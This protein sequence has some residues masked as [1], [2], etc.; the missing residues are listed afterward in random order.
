MNTKAVI[1]HLNELAHYYPYLDSNLNKTSLHSNPNILIVNLIDK[2][3]EQGE[4]GRWFLYAL[5]R[6]VSESINIFR[7]HNT[8]ITNSNSKIPLLRSSS[9][10]NLFAR[11][12]ESSFEWK[13]RIQQQQ[14]LVSMKPS[15]PLLEG[16][17]LIY[18]RDNDEIIYQGKDP[19][20]MHFLRRNK[21]LTDRDTTTVKDFVYRVVNDKLNVKFIWFDYHKRCNHGRIDETKDV[22][23]KLKSLLDDQEDKLFFFQSSFPTKSVKQLIDMQQHVIRTNCMDCLDRTNVMQ[24]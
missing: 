9:I 18:L 24:V 6:A 23:V 19:I 13:S 12:G 7:K 16:K 22:I 14:Q 17:D 3:G 4:L 8:T 2:H 1:V 21:D 20:P 10:S 11:A 5:E 15:F